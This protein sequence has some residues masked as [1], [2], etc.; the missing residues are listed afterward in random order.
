MAYKMASGI[1]IQPPSFLY[2]FTYERSPANIPN[3]HMPAPSISPKVKNTITNNQ[4]SDNVASH[5]AK[6]PIAQ[7]IKYKSPKQRGM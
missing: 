4:I 6:C 3:I 7:Y 5:N 2:G 1:T